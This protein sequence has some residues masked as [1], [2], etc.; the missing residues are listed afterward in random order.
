MKLSRTILKKTREKIH[1]VQGKFAYHFG[2]KI[3]IVYIFST[4]R[5]GSTLLK[6]LLL[7]NMNIPYYQ[8]ISVYNRGDKNLSY[9]NMFQKRNKGY[10]VAKQP[11]YFRNFQTYPNLHH[12]R[13]S[14]CILLFRHPDEIFQSLQNM[15]SDI[16]KNRPDSEYENYIHI[17]FKNMLEL[18]QNPQYQSQIVFYDNLTEKPKITLS[19]LLGFMN[20]SY[21]NIHTEYQKNLNSGGWGRDDI[22]EKFN[23]GKIIRKNTQPQPYVTGELLQLYKD[24]KANYG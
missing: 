1:Q 16:G 22:S 2:E 3:R 13:D 24:I 20:Y 14:L 11:A 12:F 15:M 10:V 21:E 23:S 9:F 19:N 7:E 5:S 8:E 6:S 18:H 17:T 4:M